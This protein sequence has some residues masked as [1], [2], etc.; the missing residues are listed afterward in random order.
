M[1]HYIINSIS[2]NLLYVNSISFNVLNLFNFLFRE[3]FNM[4]TKEQE[5]NK[6]ITLSRGFIET[7]GCLCIAE[8]N[9]EDLIGM[10]TSVMKLAAPN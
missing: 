5:I 8:E 4:I 10:I 6:G 1:I 2:F 9:R 3:E 7:L